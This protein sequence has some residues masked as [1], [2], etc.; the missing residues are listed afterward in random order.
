[1]LLSV[2]VFCD[3][4]CFSGNSPNLRRKDQEDN[5]QSSSLVWIGGVLYRTSK[6]KLTRS[7]TPKC[8]NEVARRIVNRNVKSKYSL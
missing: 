5:G 4:I 7:L 3:V 6:L 2:C 1:M 8:K